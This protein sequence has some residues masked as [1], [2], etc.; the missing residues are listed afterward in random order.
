MYR[1]IS[2]STW[3]CACVY[4]CMCAYVRVCVYLHIIYLCDCISK[5]VHKFFCVNLSAYTYVYI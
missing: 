2:V 4:V 3:V 1:S 5:Y